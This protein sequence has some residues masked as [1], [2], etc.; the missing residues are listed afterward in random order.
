M[1]ATDLDVAYGYHKYV[2]FSIKERDMPCFVSDTFVGRSGTTVSRWE[3]AFNQ[4]GGTMVN[5]AN[6]DALHKSQHDE[7]EQPGHEGEQR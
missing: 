5:L 2:V 6:T 1:T 4:R 7:Q 3:L